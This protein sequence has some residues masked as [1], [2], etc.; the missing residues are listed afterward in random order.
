MTASPHAIPADGTDLADAPGSDPG[1][2]PEAAQLAARPMIAVRLL[3]AH[4]GNVRQGLRLDPEFLASIAEAGVLVP[5]RITRTG[6][7]TYIIIDGHRRFAAAVKAG[8]SEV[9][10]DLAADRADDPAAQYLDMVNINQRHLHLAPIEEAGALFAASQAGASKTRIRKT[11]GLGKDY[12]SAALTAGQLSGETRLKTEAC[13]GLSLE[14]YALLHEFEDDPAVVDRL[15]EAFSRGESG[16]HTA[17]RIRAERAAEAEREQVLSRY[18]ENGYQIT[19]SLPQGAMP[20]QGLLQDGEELTPEAHAACPGRGIVFY[21]WD[22]DHPVHYCT[23]PAASGHVS[24]YASSATVPPA[25]GDPDEMPQN[26][27]QSQPAPVP[28]PESG[29]SHRFIVEGNRA[30]VAATAVRRRWLQALFARRNAPKEVP[31]FVASQLLAMPAPLR[32]VLTSA[33]HRTMFSELAGHVDQAQL[34]TWTAGR[35]PLLSLALIVTAYE[36]QMG[37]DSGKPT[38]REDR[39][40]P[41]SRTEAG[42]YLRFLAS[43]GY[44]LSAIEQAVADGIPY[45]GDHPADELSPGTGSQPSADVPGDAEPDGASQPDS[46]A[47]PAVI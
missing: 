15:L 45:T 42:A 39:Y 33:P 13:Y 8:Q 35:L 47:E 43:L 37:G 6:D 29:P 19:G 2:R 10:Y 44:E 27:T 7:G 11:T 22:P 4:P 34:Q 18:R 31:L 17:E 38:W 1:D 25:P 20:V 41:C 28:A 21:S 32:E 12:V 24:R 14:Q 30:W 36:E 9:P 3:A 16:Q 26:G 46:T 23:D 5:L 40:S